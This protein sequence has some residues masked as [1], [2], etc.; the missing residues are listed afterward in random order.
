MRQQTRIRWTRFGLVVLLALAAPAGAWGQERSWPLPA[1]PS[2]ADL[3]GAQAIAD[4][5]PA[6]P[7]AR[8]YGTASETV[9]VV[10]ALEFEA[11]LSTDLWGN[12]ESGPPHIGL[13]RV[14]GG[15]VALWAPIHL[16]AGALITR[17]E[18]DGFDDNA[19]GQISSVVMG[20]KSPGAAASVLATMAT[21]TAA[22]PGSGTF[23]YTFAG[24]VTRADLTIDNVNGYYLVSVSMNAGGLG[25]SNV[26][27]HYRL[28]VS[29]APGVASFTDVP[30]SHPFFQF[31]EAL[32]ASGI[33]AG[34][35]VDHFC[36][37]DGLT[38]GQMAVFLS[39]ALGLHFAP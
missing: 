9:Y 2:L 13:Y 30:T 36:P 27:V 21:G 17:I 26:R 34:C 33:T 12:L 19:G 20:L 3:V 38:R 22:T 32:K 39:K 35:S 28:Q 29:P 25:F 1:V 4:V 7:V 18:L 14:V 16:P 11:Q 15:V 31:V 5:A 10:S 6:S 23:P 8:T 24:G 37:D